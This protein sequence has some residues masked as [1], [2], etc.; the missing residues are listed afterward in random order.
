MTNKQVKALNIY[1]PY[2]AGEPAMATDTTGCASREPHDRRRMSSNTLPSAEYLA[3]FFDA[4]GCVHAGVGGGEYACGV[5]KTR[6]QL[7]VATWTRDQPKAFHDRYGGN[8]NSNRVDG[9][10]NPKTHRWCLSG[11]G[12][13]DALEDL[14]PHLRLKRQQAEAMLSVLEDRKQIGDVRPIPKEH[15]ENR[16]EVVKSIRRIKEEEKGV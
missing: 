10:D 14:I 9:D 7:V 11:V 16:V 5:E 12:A 13:I 4:D 15:A 1:V 6:F 2:M 8:F 3:G